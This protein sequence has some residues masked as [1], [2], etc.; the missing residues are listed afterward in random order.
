MKNVYRKHVRVCSWVCTG[1]QL[2]SFSVADGYNFNKA[3][4]SSVK[5]SF[6]VAKNFIN[7]GAHP[8]RRIESNITRKYLP[9]EPAYKTIL[10]LN[11]QF[12]SLILS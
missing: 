2:G 6:C 1:A 7:V 9:L 11:L 3:A 8:K 5:H 4:H 10:A 12:L